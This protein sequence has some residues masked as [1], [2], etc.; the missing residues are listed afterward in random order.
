MA[1]HAYTR[2]QSVEAWLV[3]LGTLSE[4]SLLASLPRA[5]PAGMLLGACLQIYRTHQQG[6]QRQEDQAAT[7][8]VPVRPIVRMTMP[9]AMDE[10]V[11]EAEKRERSCVQAD[12]VALEGDAAA[13]Q[14]LE[15][16]QRF[17]AADDS[18]Q[19]RMT[20][21]AEPEGV[22]LRLLSSGVELSS[23][24]VEA[25]P[26]TVAAVTAVRRQL[27]V[28]LERAVFGQ[29]ASIQSDRVIRALRQVR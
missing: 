19:L 26:S 29:A 1:K 16:M 17:A 10:T 7:R 12:V 3:A 18:S 22:L 27:D 28:G 8:P 4:P 23:L 6:L 2:N 11:S 21:D 24:S 15:G 14:R 13:M 25:E 20:L 5:Q 9:R